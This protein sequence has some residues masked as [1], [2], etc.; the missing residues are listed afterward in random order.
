M[1]KI[2]L[3]QINVPK[4]PIKYTQTNRVDQHKSSDYQ[5]SPY[6]FA[7]TLTLNDINVFISKNN[8]DINKK[9]LSMLKEINS[10]IFMAAIIGSKLISDRLY[11][12]VSNG[13]YD[14][15]DEIG[16]INDLSDFKTEIRKSVKDNNHSYS[17]FLRKSYR[18]FEKFYS[19]K[20]K[21][22]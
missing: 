20:T 3:V 6:N 13:V 21:R 1:S 9:T 18:G 10:L 12:I 11:V 14:F 8:I 19:I 16:K 5:L 15:F 17:D 2:S 22:N 4:Y 7:K